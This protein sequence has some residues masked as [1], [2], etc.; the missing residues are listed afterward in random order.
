MAMEDGT[1]GSI[2]ARVAE[3]RFKTETLNRLD[4][5]GRVRIA[6]ALRKVFDDK[7]VAGVV[8]SGP[9]G[10]FPAANDP[11][12]EGPSLADLC[13]LIEGAPKPVAAAIGQGALGP[14][15]DI[16][17]AAHFRFAADKAVLGYPEVR[18]GLVPEAGGSQRLPRLVGAAAALDVLLSGRAVPA[19]LATKTGMIDGAVAG[20]PVAHA[21]RYVQGQVAA[22]AALEP[23]RR[24]TRRLRD[25][26]GY[27]AACRARRETVE[28]G[29]L[30][31]PRRMI[32]CVEAA[33][34]LPFDE[35]LAFEA[36]TRAELLNSAE[37]RALAHISRAEAM[38]IAPKSLREA[39]PRDVET[40]GIA[41]AG[42]IGT[43]LSLTA[44]AGG[45]S[46]VLWER[47]EARLEEAVLTIIEATDAEVEAGRLTSDDGKARIARLAGAYGAS[48]LGEAD[49]LIEALSDAGGGAEAAIA[50][51]DGAMKAGAVLALT[52][53]GD[54]LAGL[55]AATSRAADILGLRVFPPLRRF[56]AAELRQGRET[57][58]VAGST[59]WEVLKRLGRMPVITAGGA[60]SDAL[61][62][63]FYGGADWCLMAGA[64]VEEIDRAMRNWGARLGP[65]EA[66]DL[67]GGGRVP[68]A[69]AGG[70]DKALWQAGKR[71]YT[72]RPNG[73]RAGPDPGIEAILDAA[74]KRGGFER[75]PVEA[76]E[77]VARCLTAMAN[78]GARAVRERRVARPAEID[79]LAVHGLGLPRW[80]GGPLV[81]ADIEGLLKLE[82]RL[83]RFSADVPALWTPDPL[84]GTLVKNGKRFGSLNG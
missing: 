3:V 25:A 68:S 42:R 52:G 63:A 60:V 46:V 78:A 51:L 24:K 9:D 31:A 84:V 10:R 13:A 20:D 71:Y 81:N 67:A 11:G 82:K 38:R 2:D 80:R 75:R 83:K 47:D 53:A 55:A 33:L 65:F 37:A 7:S 62:A 5:A 6:A 73:S 50:A 1:T 59:A 4:A 72:Y 32:D 34:L 77:I 79:L 8:L 39:R 54:N 12:G 64:N 76:E 29:R 27:L 58:V 26:G 74:R 49:F 69:L 23:T 41:G 35:G 43:E 22:G 70:L 44:L 18:L 21:V 19:P 36:E 61:A 15:C 30:T 57:S 66:R 48:S 28:E 17:L 40:L 14:G 45:F 56:R 16:V